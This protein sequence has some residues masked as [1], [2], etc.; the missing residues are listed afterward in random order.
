M[1]AREF[2]AEKLRELHAKFPQIQIRYEY[3]MSTQSHLIEVMP[4]HFFENDEAYAHEEE[5]IRDEFESLF[6]P[7]D[8][9]FI[10]EG[11]LTEIEY[12][13][14]ELG[15]GERIPFDKGTPDIKFSLDD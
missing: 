12:A 13:D 11:F 9:L 14:L 10:S 6:L 5:K 8:I 15:Y 2:I 4:L 3:R 7:E 1:T